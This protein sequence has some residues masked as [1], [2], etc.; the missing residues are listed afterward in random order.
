V[1]FG[2]IGRNRRLD[3]ILQALAEFPDRDA[4]H[5]DIFGQLEN[6]ESV[7]TRLKGS[8]LTDI[9]TVHGFVSEE[10]LNAA[11]DAAHLAVNL[12][13]PS[14]GEASA[15]Q[16]R[17]WDHALPSLVTP[18]GWYALLPEDTVAFVRPDHEVEDLQ[19]HWRGFLADPDRFTRMGERG[20]LLLEEQHA[21][22]IYVQTLLDFIGSPRCLHSRASAVHLAKRIGAEV[23][24]WLNA[25]PPDDLLRPVA[26]QIRVL[27][28]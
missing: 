17:I 28:R 12:R 3:Q 6:P 25:I 8:R 21:P 13:F 5:L 23:G 16:L 19:A 11:L 27:T 26:E 18:T 10:K 20:R 7:R 22:E 2:Y 1:L 14:M 4:F 9:V 24:P 15:S